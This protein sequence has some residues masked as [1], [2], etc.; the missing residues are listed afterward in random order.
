MRE[1]A[2]SEPTFRRRLLFASALFVT[3]FVA[4]L[5]LVSDLAFRDLSHRVIDQALRDAL[6]ALEPPT[7]LPSSDPGQAGPPQESES[8][9]GCPPRSP[10]SSAEPKPCALPQRP[11]RGV[12]SEVFR[13]T[14]TLRLKRIVADTRG[15]VLQ[16]AYEQTTRIES[17]GASRQPLV[18]GHLEVPEEW[19]LGGRRQQVIALRNQAAPGSDEIKEVGIPR[20]MIESEVAQIQRDLQM[21]LWIGAGVAALI[22]LVA[23]LYVLR[24]LQRTRLQEARAQMD[25]RLAHVGA[26]A[27]GLAHEIRNP[28]NVLSMNLQMLEEEIA[29]RP[30]GGESGDAR[31]YLSALQGE[32]RRL[33]NLVNNFL[34]YARP[35]L[36]NFESKDLN[37]V[38]REVTLFVKPEFETRGLTLRQDLSPYLPPVEMDEAQI[39]QAV[40]NILINA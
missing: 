23:F 26:L 32:I 38:L 33:S 12:P 13:S 16:M 35:N 17:G 8:T 18:P 10:Q 25:D 36:S 3:L 34:S 30:V 5:F 15:H 28:L 24:L 6:N 19:D 21:K 20:D 27:A 14:S 4:D 39:R 22:L 9:E 1:V 31:L 37:Q 7:P 11:P 40:M 29:G 2:R